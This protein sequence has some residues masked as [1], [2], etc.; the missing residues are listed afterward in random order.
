[1]IKDRARTA[2]K[3]GAL[4]G[5]NP[6]RIE[7]KIRARGRF[8]WISRNVPAPV[9][10]AIKAEKLPGICFQ[11]ERRRHYPIGM[12][13]GHILGLV[14]RDQQGLCGIERLYDKTLS[15]VAPANSKI[16]RGDVYLSLDSFVQ[17]VAERE[18][19]WGVKKSGAKRGMVLA[20]DPNTG[21]V[22]AMAYWPPLSLDPDASPNP[23]DMRVPGLVDV[24]EPGSTFKI[25]VAAAV[26][27]EKAIGPHETFDGEKGAWKVKDVTIHDHEPLQHMSLEDI[28]V[29][30]S[31]IGASKLAERLGAER[32][33]E[34]ARL[35]GFGVFPGSGFTSEA[36]GVLRPLSKW[37]GVSKYM[38]S[39]GQEIGVTG[40]QIVGAYSAIAN[41]GIL[42]E[43][44]L[45]EKIVGDDGKIA[46]QSSPSEVRRVVSKPTAAEVTR[47]LEAVVDKGTGVHASISWDPNMKVAGKT[48]TAQKW[49]AVHHRYHD[50]LALVS[51]AGFFPADKPK[52]AMLVVLDEPE[53]R[54]WGGL[55]AAPVFRRIAE[56]IA[57]HLNSPP[58]VM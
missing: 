31:N 39:F 58:G 55:D 34:Y 4:L 18:L 30:S 41:G 11:T 49:D 53:G 3:L 21:D 54:R 38:V 29:H 44:R 13:A 50:I 46:W 5:M 19:E 15:A 12:L 52:V 37:S 33:Y 48:G 24:F 51:F 27:E 35:F 7:A 8:V 17:Q 9:V 47:I 42:M 22:L 6:R 32:L 1:L 40:I 56:Q 20:Q 45:V 23:L 10:S 14:G 2:A 28:I 26:L 57:G 25:V 16:P 43:P 36:R